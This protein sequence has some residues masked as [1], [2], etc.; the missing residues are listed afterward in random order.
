LILKQDQLDQV[1]SSFAF[2]SKQ[3]FFIFTI[4]VFQ[5]LFDKATNPIKLYPRK[6][7]EKEGHIHLSEP[8][9]LY[10][11]LSNPTSRA[12]AQRSSIQE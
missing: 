11:I 4:C 12:K 8:S 7:F 5:F 1:Y 9:F 3:C 6:R 10:W 2:S